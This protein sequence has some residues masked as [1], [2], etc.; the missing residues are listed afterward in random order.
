M[1]D[2]ELDHDMDLLVDSVESIRRQLL[3]PN[4]N[5]AGKL[6]VAEFKSLIKG[7]R[8]VAVSAATREIRRKRGRSGSRPLVSTGKL[9]SSIEILSR[10][11]VEFTVGSTLKKA[12]FL[13]SGGVTDRASAIPG[14]TVP[15]RDY[16]LVNKEI[17]ENVARKV[18]DNLK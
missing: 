8:F 5:E 3:N 1:F 4:L 11:R 6:V 9:Q 7:G 12:R 14:K 15:R 2:I 18:L 17:L 13:R 16:M 10:K